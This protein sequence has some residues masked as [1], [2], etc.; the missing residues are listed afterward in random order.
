MGKSEISQRYAQRAITRQVKTI[1]SDALL[2][3]PKVH[4]LGTYLHHTGV[5]ALV[6]S[7]NKK[8]MTSHLRPNSIWAGI[9]VITC[10]HADW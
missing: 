2:A 6:V 10:I 3:E 9:G 5:V 4:S 7:Q 1:L 8:D